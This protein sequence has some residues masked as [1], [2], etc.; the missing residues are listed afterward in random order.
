MGVLLAMVLACGSPGS[1]PDAAGSTSDAAT[2]DAPADAG[3]S[4]PDAGEPVHVNGGC[5]DVVT[6]VLGP[7]G[8][9]LRLCDAVWSVGLYAVGA[10]TTHVLRRSAETP[11]GLP[12]DTVPISDV[13]TLERTE[14]TRCWSISFTLPYVA[15]ATDEGHLWIAWRA[16]DTTRWRLFEPCLGEPGVS[17]G[18]T[19]DWL[20]EVV[21]VHDPNTYVRLDD[22]AR[23]GTATWSHGAVGDVS[24][25]GSASFEEPEPG[26]REGSFFFTGPVAEGRVD[27]SGDFT[28]DASGAVLTRLNMT[29]F[30]GATL[31][32]WT[33]DGSGAMTIER[34]DGTRL[35]ARIQTTL[36]RGGDR[37]QPDGP[38]DLSFDVG[39]LRTRTEPDN[40]CCEPEI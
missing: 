2:I 37:T 12:P 20:G 5:G 38:L 33:T 23:S 11:A 16:P 18:V 4:L 10:G 21:V 17:A 40:W 31:E 7:A 13:F 3:Y 35:V 24:G 6:A 9:S 28:L 1:D 36:L 30:I 34:D 29:R 14:P 39:F 27:V 26:V 22:P 19:S 8:G 25:E 32:N 15:P